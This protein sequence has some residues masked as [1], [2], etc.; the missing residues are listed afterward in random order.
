MKCLIVV[1]LLINLSL[2]KKY[3]RCELAKELNEKHDIAIKHVGMFVC[4]AEVRSSLN[5]EAV[6]SGLYYGLYQVKFKF[7]SYYS[8]CYLT[9]IILFS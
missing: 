8:I 2:A 4:V 5:T 9:I 3:Q 7:Y 6:N 1:L